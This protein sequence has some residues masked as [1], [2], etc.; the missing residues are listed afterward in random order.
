MAIQSIQRNSKIFVNSLKSWF[1]LYVGSSI[2]PP[3]LSLSLSLSVY[4]SLLSIT[5]V[6]SLQSIKKTNLFSSTDFTHRETDKENH[7]GAAA[8][9]LRGR[10]AA[11]GP[12]RIH[13]TPDVHVRR[14]LK[15]H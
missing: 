15:N 8:K 12:V 4:L 11:R 10:A 1:H 3:S 14:R 13:G 9:R 6:E 5:S 7:G 2:P